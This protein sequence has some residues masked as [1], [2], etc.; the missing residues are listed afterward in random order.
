MIFT[1]DEQNNITAFGSSEEAAATTTPFDSFGSEKDLADLAAGWPAA[2]LVAIWNS[3]P[4]VTPV[5]RFKSGNGAVG[6]I[7]E[8]IQGLG[9]V[10]EPEAEPAKG[11]SERKAKRGVRAATSAATKGKA[12]KKATAAKNAPKAKTVAKLSKKATPGKKAPKAPKAAPSRKATREGSKTET[13]LALMQRPGGATLAALMDATRWQAHSVRGFISAVVN[14]KM[15]LT[16]E[17]GKAEGG[18]RTYSIA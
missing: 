11:H 18:E 3:L 8:R 4:G 5:K 9:E 1:I 10:A 2:R 6:R 13:I 15:G 14:K 16:V 17:S 12:T 7:W